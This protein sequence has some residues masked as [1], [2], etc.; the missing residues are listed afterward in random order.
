[1]ITS[2]NE[3]ALVEE[4]KSLKELRSEGRTENVARPSRVVGSD[5]HPG[6]HGLVGYG[7]ELSERAH[8]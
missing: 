8:Q 7:R 5:S 4:E 1:M 3:I 6:A 2:E